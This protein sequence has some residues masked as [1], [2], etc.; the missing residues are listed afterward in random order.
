MTNFDFH[1]RLWCQ[2]IELKNDRLDRLRQKNGS[3][4]LISFEIKKSNKDNNLN[5]LFGHFLL[6]LVFCLYPIANVVGRQEL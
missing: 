5:F 3:I 2:K 4:K 1:L 6:W